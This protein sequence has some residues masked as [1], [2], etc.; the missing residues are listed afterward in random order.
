MAAQNTSTVSAAEVA[1]R[2][3]VSR[4]T[5]YRLAEQGVIPSIRVGRQFRFDLAEVEAALKGG[6]R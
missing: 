5:V 3:A 4:R 2:Y 1:A 6:R